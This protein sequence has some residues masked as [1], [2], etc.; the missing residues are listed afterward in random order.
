M[1]I[2]NHI[3]VVEVSTN[4][5]GWFHRCVEVDFFLAR[6][7]R[8]CIWQRIRLNLCCQR[9]LGIDALGIPILLVLLNNHISSGCGNIDGDYG[10]DGEHHPLWN[11]VEHQGILL[12]H[13]V[14]DTCIYDGITQEAARCCH[15]RPCVHGYNIQID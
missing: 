15:G 6:E 13:F 7:G 1:I 5:F 8:E 10:G 11:I 9:K 3:E 4:F 14:C 12:K 2:V